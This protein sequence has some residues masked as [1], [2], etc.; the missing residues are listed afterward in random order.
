MP[1]IL[2][3]SL[4]ERDAARRA[5]TAAHLPPEGPAVETLAEL[6]AFDEPAR[7][8][9]RER[10]ATL[11]ERIRERPNPLDSFLHEYDLSS[12][13]GV[14]LMCL[15]EGLLRIP[16][17]ETADRLIHDKLGSADWDR[18]LGHSASL[19]VNAS[20]WGL[21]L[22]G[23]LVGLSPG[24]DSRPSGLLGPILGRSSEPV[25][26]SALKQAMHLLARQ[27]VM[28]RHIG[29]AL[30]RARTGENRRYRHSF[31][32]LGEAA[33]SETDAQAYIS[34]YRRAAYAAGMATEAGQ[35]LLA[36]PGISIKLSALHPRFERSQSLRVREELTP[37]LLDLLYRART[38]GIP[39][40]VDAEE[41]ERLEP[42]LDVLEAA[43]RDPEL[44]DWEGVGLAVQAYQKRAL[45]VLD[46]VGEQAGR[47]GARIPVRLV[48]GAYWDTEIKRAQQEGLSDYPVFTR[49][50]HTDISYL[51]CARRLAELGGRVFPQF[52]THNAH[53][54]AAVYELMGA[55]AD[56]EFQRLHGMG[57]GLY[58][59][60][61]DGWGLPCRV[62]APVGGHR[63]LLPYLVRRLLENGANSSF[64]NRIADK[65]AE[66]EALLA[67][68]VETWRSGDTEGP[69]LPLPRD[70]YPDR[71]NS[72]GLPRDDPDVLAQLDGTLRTA[73]AGAPWRATP[74]IDGRRLPGSEH[75]VTAPADHRITAGTVAEAGAEQATAAMAGAAEAFPAWCRTP[76]EERASILERAADRIETE[77]AGLMARIIREG[78]RTV[79]DALAE[80][81]EAADFCRYYAAMARDQLAE[82][83]L[84]GPT[85]ERN[86]LRAEGRGA[87]L[88]ISPW[89]FP[90]AIFTGQ[91]AA[92]LVAGNTVVAKPARATPLTAMRIIELLAEAGVPDSALQFLPGPSGALGPAIL[93]D[94]RLAGVALTGGTGTARHI[95]HALAERDGPL[96]PLIAETGGVNALIA[97]SSALPEQVARDVVRS[98]FNSAGQRCSALRVLFLQEE[99]ADAMLAAI[100]GATAE[101]RV[102]DPAR[103]D[104]DLGPVIDENAR[105][106]LAEHARRLDAEAR[107]VAWTDPLPGAPPGSFFGPRIYELPEL[108]AL[109]GEVFGPILHVVRYRAG[110]LDRVIAAINGTG[111]GLTLGVHSRVEE[112]ARY[113]A[114]R[115]NAGN[116]YI[117]RDIIGSVVGVQPFGGR[118]LSG[119]G[120]KAGGPHYLTRFLHEKTVTDNIA[121]VGGNA[122]L[123]GGRY[124]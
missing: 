110:E 120:P 93:G 43:F 74:R 103:L 96:V 100:A 76:V 56:Y 41:A 94:P 37:R 107:L 44:A 86:A 95:Q 24:L 30:Q 117:N 53:T 3:L 106:E 4:P 105:A 9:I 104:T 14:L 79:P 7:Q 63:E 20:T 65:R 15:A 98:A 35:P 61:V 118:G 12:Q 89:N 8:R 46:W 88:C 48:K 50:T 80:V 119:T 113:V 85:G 122:T 6:A 112:T 109:P 62:Y 115:A 18:H 54:I 116:V 64:I 40:T 111:Y 114:E 81:R 13:E 73:W 33:V 11:V 21:M 123:L 91:I 29:E 25:V 47:R 22:T 68:P 84:P 82:R 71:A 5:V 31:D 101:L 38:A 92:A 124:G 23:R 10:G 90:A 75:A 70:I 55:E 87:F 16:D 83:P 52:A 78:G 72:A 36:R 2:G 102:G 1:T 69:A 19:L 45:P 17:T 66:P 57:A 58:D 67:D 39:V 59:T 60:V 77:R 121:A 34:A 99:V 108:E 97:D 42:S 26:R 27:F 32:M 49:K 28:G 51:A